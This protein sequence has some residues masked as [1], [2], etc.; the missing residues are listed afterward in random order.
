MTPLEVT[1]TRRPF[2]HLF[3]HFTLTYSNW[4]TGRICVSE[5]FES[6]SEG[7]QAALWELGGVPQVH[8]TNLQHNWSTIRP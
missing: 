7:L 3:Y 5:S 1:I 2:D 8:H 6:V 4:E